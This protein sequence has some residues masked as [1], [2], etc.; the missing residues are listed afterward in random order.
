MYKVK[1]AN[2][3][4]VALVIVA[5]LTLPLGAGNA[6]YAAHN[7]STPGIVENHSSKAI[8]IRYDDASGV[9]HQTTVPAGQNSSAYD[10]DVDQFT[11]T[12]GSFTVTGTVYA[13]GYF[14][15]GGIGAG[16]I[17]WSVWRCFDGGSGTSGVSCLRFL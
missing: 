16:S 13:S 15:P 9:I 11:V 7:C 1:W 8:V 5:T 12:S 14:Y 3:G 10:C 4:L 2:R 17:G 6:A